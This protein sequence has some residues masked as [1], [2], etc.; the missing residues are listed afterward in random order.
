MSIPNASQVLARV[1]REGS[2]TLGISVEQT[3]PPTPKKPLAL[4]ENE[5]ILQ[6]MMGQSGNK[7]GF[8]RFDIEDNL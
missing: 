2:N 3:A 4:I 6:Y 1:L 7:V 8:V 5:G